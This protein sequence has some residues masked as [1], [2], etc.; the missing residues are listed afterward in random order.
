M[1]PGQQVEIHGVPLSDIV[2]HFDLEV[3]SDGGV[4]LA[5]R[6]ITTA[7]VNRPGLQWAGYSE[8]FPT[9]RIQLIGRAEL[10][11]M[12]TL[13]EETGW[14]RLEQYAQMGM[15][16]VIL[17]RNLHFD[18]RGIEMS[19]DYGIPV[20]RTPMPTSDFA[21]QL[22]WFLAMELAPRV[23]LHAGLVDVAGEGVLILGRSGIGKSET[24][25]E[26]IRRGHRL[27]ADDTVEVRRPSEHDLIGR[28]PGRMRYFM[29]IKGIGIVN[30]RLLYGIGSVKANADLSMVVALEHLVPD[31]D[32]SKEPDRTEILGVTLPLV[33]IPVRPG[34][35]TAVLIETAAMDIR[36]RRLAHHGGDRSDVRLH[37]LESLE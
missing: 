29:E 35:N 36:A 25:L 1:A 3:V 13:S 16:A 7:Q 21:S 33:T 22:N 11:Y 23:V 15:P 31:R 12:M 24:A 32:F 27:I 17:A 2:E 6:M 30:L 37:M 19:L 5:A 4:E 26:L 8:H 18:P 10:G 28:A 34:R 20:L 14:T 9:D